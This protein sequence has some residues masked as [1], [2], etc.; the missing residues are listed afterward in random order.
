MPERRLASLA[1]A[2]GCAVVACQAVSGLS[3]FGLGSSEKGPASAGPGASG[4][5]A[6]GSGGA[7]ASGSK[8]S[9]STSVTSDTTAVSDT[10]VTTDGIT[11]SVDS[12]SSPAVTAGVGGAS[13]MASSASGVGGL[14]AGGDIN[15]AGC[16]QFAFVSTFKVTGKIPTIAFADAGCNNEAKTLAPGNPVAD[17]KW[18]ALLST[19]A[20]MGA[21][22][23]RI[24]IGAQGVC[25]LDGGN[26]FSVK[27]ADGPQ[28]WTANH[29]AAIDHTADGKPVAATGAWT[30]TTVTGGV[31]PNCKDFT[32][33]AQADSGQVGRTD[34]TDANWVAFFAMPS[35]DNP[36]PLYC[37]SV[38]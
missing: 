38:P 17:G 27:I 19:S 36:L 28:W 2:L 30:G 14:G 5:V 31:A 8:A 10:S 6:S 18:R 3:G 32:S 11:A 37:V 13:P 12:A 20:K 16:N 7:T 25:L 9:A 26:K 35:C 22:V 29:L 21:A 23:F 33:D 4:S 24:P 15:P 34:K 1:L